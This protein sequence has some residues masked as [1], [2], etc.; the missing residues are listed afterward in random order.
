MKKVKRVDCIDCKNFKF[1]MFSKE[2]NKCTLGKRVMFRMPK[3]PDDQ[4]CGYIRYC[5]DFNPTIDYENK[6]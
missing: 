1:S 3:F 5:N 4:D 6:V 2:E